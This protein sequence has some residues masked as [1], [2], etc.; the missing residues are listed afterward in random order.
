MNR[1][2]ARTQEREIGYEK[3]FEEERTKA[4]TKTNSTRSDA[5]ALDQDGAV[6]EVGKHLCP[7]LLGH[8]VLVVVRLAVHQVIGADLDE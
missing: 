8:V 7:Q 4:G 2:Q 5:S 6:L 1:R 3:P